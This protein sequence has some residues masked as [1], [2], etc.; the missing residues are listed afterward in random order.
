MPSDNASNIK[1]FGLFVQCSPDVQKSF[2]FLYLVADE[3]I[4]RD[5]R[6]DRYYNAS[7]RTPGDACS[8]VIEVLELRVTFRL[9]YVDPK[10]GRCFYT[11]YKD[12]Q[13]VGELLSEMLPDFLVMKKK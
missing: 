1:I 7:V 5:G 2:G 4:Y 10:G 3:F 8:Y 9:Q 13:E 6:S 12:D 11:L